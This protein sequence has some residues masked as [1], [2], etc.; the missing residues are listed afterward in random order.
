MEVIAIANQKGGV[1]KSVTAAALSAGLSF[2]GYR[3]LSVDLDA[4]RNFS[5]LLHARGGVTILEVLTGEA[6]VEEATQRMERGD[7]IAASPQLVAADFLVKGARREYRLQDALV[8]IKEKYD[9]VVLDTPPALGTLTVNALTAASSVVVPALADVF[10]VQ[11]VLEFGETVRNIQR[12]SNPA[13]RHRGIL[14]TRYS[15]R[16]IISRDMA[17]T[18]REAAQRD[19]TKVFEI[20][21]R[22]AVAIREAAARGTD[23]FSYA[24][25]S[26][27]SGDYRAFIEELLKNITERDGD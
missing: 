2:K 8:P 17:D 12:R 26:K 16:S 27:A 10:S 15:G 11:G 22:E 19:G 4:Q 9:F 3:V 6:T 24:P 18:L 1:G 5:F 7:A 21:I 13:L 14:I 25:K 20:A 23:I